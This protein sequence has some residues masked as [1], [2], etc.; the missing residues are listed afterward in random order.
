M[1]FKLL[2]LVSSLMLLASSHAFATTVY[3]FDTPLSNGAVPAG[4]VSLNVV[5]SNATFTVSLP[6]NYIFDGFALNL[7]SPSNVTVT[8]SYGPITS[9]SSPYSI[10]VTGKSSP[11]S[12]IPSFNTILGS[13]S[14]SF[15]N[16]LT[17]TVSNYTGIFSDTFQESNGTSVPIY[18]AAEIYNSGQS[19]S[20]TFIGAD[21]IQPVVTP[22]P[23]ALPLFAGGLG[24]LALL[25]RRRNRASPA[26][27]S[28]A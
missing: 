13:G 19:P 12:N 8:S 23:G 5:G 6:T 11:W 26:P 7:N 21:S 16:T 2:G 24:V 22:L 10:I 28:T 4:T 14:T 9:N 15:G 17:F 18:F 3:D 20:I 25:R 27:S 1:K